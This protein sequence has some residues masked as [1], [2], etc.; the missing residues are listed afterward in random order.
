VRNK[1]KKKGKI[2]KLL[3]WVLP[4]GVVGLIIAAGV[5]LWLLA[6]KNQ[7]EDEPSDK[8]EAPE[9]IVYRGPPRNL[10]QLL[11]RYMAAQGGEEKIEMVQSLRIHGRIIADGVEIPFDQIKRAPNMSRLTLETEP[12]AITTFN[13]GEAVW[14][15]IEGVPNLYEVTGVEANDIQ[16]NSAILSPVWSQRNEPGALEWRGTQEIDGVAHH[17]ILLNQEDSPD[18]VYWID[19]EE[20]WER[21]VDTA[22]PNGEFLSTTFDDFRRVGWLTIPFK[23]VSERDGEVVSEIIIDRAEINIGVL[24]AF[25]ETP[26][27]LEPWPGTKE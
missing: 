8:N 13:N 3:E 15:E 20:Y 7:S 19:G 22:T 21:R 14:R 17:R 26:E 1:S 5:G 24:S 23:I 6:E 16:A 10:E 2:K 18:R 4:I 25:F 9:K 12:R 11:E 27:K